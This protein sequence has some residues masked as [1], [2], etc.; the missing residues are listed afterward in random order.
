MKA[1]QARGWTED[2]TL[3]RFI[4]DHVFGTPDECFEKIKA[5]RDKVGA[6]GYIAI[7]NYIDMSREE[8]LRNQTLF[9]EKVLPRLKAYMPELDIGRPSPAVSLK[10]A[11]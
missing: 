9:A 11:G 2:N 6:A 10:K 4:V 7:L 1:A 5:T 8:S 3:D